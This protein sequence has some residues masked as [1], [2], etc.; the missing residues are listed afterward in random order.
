MTT[1]KQ[2]KIASHPAAT[3]HIGTG[4][5]TNAPLL[6]LKTADEAAFQVATASDESSRD[7][8][9]PPSNPSPIELDTEPE[10]KDQHKP[11]PTNQMGKKNVN[12]LN[13]VIT[14]PLLLN[15]NDHPETIEEA[16]TENANLMPVGEPPKPDLVKELDETIADNENKNTDI[17]SSDDT[18]PYLESDKNQDSDLNDEPK[19]PKGR[20]VTKKYGLKH[21]PTYH[22]KYTCSICG[23]VERTAH[24][25]NEHHRAKHPPVICN[26]CGKV[27]QTPLSLEWCSYTHNEKPFQCDKCNQGFQFASELVG[28]RIK[29]RTIKVF[30][31]AYAKCGKSFMHKLELTAHSI[32]HLG[33]KYTCDCGNYETMDIRLYRQHQRTHSDKKRYTCKICSEKFKHTTQM[34]RHK[35]NKH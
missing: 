15:A 6:P 1:N 13:E 10:T 20:L 2:D 4:K 24:D 21:K 22:R 27:C 17:H 31:C 12:E 14:G 32:T 30:I 7:M 9:L 23:M 11:T 35:K 25:I 8:P 19:S 18:E 5:D 16:L 34:L 3:S 33:K 28:H 29:H 26:I